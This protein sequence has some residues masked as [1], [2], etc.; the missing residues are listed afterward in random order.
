MN[1][2]LEEK[3]Y[4]DVITVY[5]KLNDPESK[6]K[7]KRPVDPITIELFFEALVEKVG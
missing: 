1:K 4:D 2:L 6:A 3:R 7:N 5:N